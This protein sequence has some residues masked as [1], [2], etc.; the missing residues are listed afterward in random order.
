[1]GR[2]LLIRLKLIKFNLY[3]LTDLLIDPNHGLYESIDIHEVSTFNQIKYMGEGMGIRF[4]VTKHELMTT[5]FN[6]WA[7]PYGF[8]NTNK[9]SNLWCCSCIYDDQVILKLYNLLLGPS[10]STPIFNT[11]FLHGKGWVKVTCG[12]VDLLIAFSR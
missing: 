2:H 3:G 10:N 4:S 5:F 11:T 9:H 6:G 7:R 12:I 8:Y 1:V